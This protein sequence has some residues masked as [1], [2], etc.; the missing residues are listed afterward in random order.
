[1]LF[2]I[3]TLASQPSTVEVK[4]NCKFQKFDKNKLKHGDDSD[5]SDVLPTLEMGDIVEYYT[6]GRFSV[7]NMI[8]YILNVTGKADVLI[9]TWAMTEAPLRTISRL[10]TEGKIGKL[11][12]LLEHKV[13]GHNPKS[14]AFAKQIFDEIWLGKCHAKVIVIE[15]EN[16]QVVITTSANLT[17]NRRIESG[18]IKCIKQ[19]ADFNREWINNQKKKCT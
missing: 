12:C 1:M 11:E 3:R 19:S 10:K 9:A 7:H 8:E 5:L 15:N 14:Y 2:S 18:D 4:P 6:E 13:P 16:W 17:R